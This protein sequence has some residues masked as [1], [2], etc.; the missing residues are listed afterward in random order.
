V[1]SSV[2]IAANSSLSDQRRRHSNEVEL[3]SVAQQ[4]DCRECDSLERDKHSVVTDNIDAQP[5]HCIPLSY[6]TV[7]Q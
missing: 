5:R 2:L 4:R 3:S 1:Q 6:V 7:Y